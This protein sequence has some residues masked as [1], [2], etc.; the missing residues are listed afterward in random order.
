MSKKVMMSV[1]AGGTKTKVALIDFEKNILFEKVGESGSP[2]VLK[3]KAIENIVNLVKDSISEN[4]GLYDIV[5]IQM[6]ISGLGVVKDKAEY[7]KKLSE[8]LNIPVSME[9]DAMMALYSSVT[10]E[11]EEGIVIL[12]GTG[13]AVCG[14]NKNDLVMLNGGWG[15]LLTEDGSSY[16]AVR[17]LVI[18]MIG[19][20][21]RGEEICP[22]GQKMMAILEVTDLPN[23][24]NFIYYKTKDEVASF[25]RLI[26]S[27]AAK[28]D[29]D[30]LEILKTSAVELANR[31]ITLSKRLGISTEEG[32]SV[33]GFRGGFVSNIPM[34]REEILKV[35]EK[36]G[37]FF[38]VA[39]GKIDPV[40]GGFYM[41]KR[42]KA[43]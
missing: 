6:G 14:I 19:E 31:V 2:A 38:S 24:R 42:K 32:K 36:N 10:D 35:L 37:Y 34:V 22:L 33:L 43:F 11:Y 1:D 20:Y 3:E 7:E 29:A 5:Y 21:E 18:K 17:S 25:S 8:E 15:H 30:A 39:D 9:N 16:S 12:S 28:G 26:S 27:E 13:S 41:A 4:N 40:Y 23:I